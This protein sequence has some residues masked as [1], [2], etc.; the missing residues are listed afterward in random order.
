[1]MLQVSVLRSVR[2]MTLTLYDSNLLWSCGRRHLVRQ[3]NGPSTQFSDPYRVTCQCLLTYICQH[4]AVEQHLAICK[5]TPL[6][7]YSD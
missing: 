6:V 5:S 2:S 7:V 1:M 4:V 3:M